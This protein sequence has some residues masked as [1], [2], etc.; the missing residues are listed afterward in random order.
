M[1]NLISDLQPPTKTQ[2]NF[3]TD[4]AYED[5]LLSNVCRRS[6]VHPELAAKWMERGSQDASNGIDSNF[7]DFYYKVREAQ[8]K[9]I[10]ETLKKISGCPRNWQ[11]LAWYLE[12]C[13]REDFSN[14][15]E[16]YKKLLE[17]YQRIIQD[18]SRIKD[19]PKANLKGVIINGQL[20]TK[21]D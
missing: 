7:S 2:I 3:F 10:S 6:S 11:S 1:N 5:L 20:D 19:M 4:R 17:D 8:S 21:S 14:E 18:I 15:A 13:F 12:K 9:K 16:M